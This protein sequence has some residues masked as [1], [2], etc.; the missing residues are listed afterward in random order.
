[1]NLISFE[2][3]EPL[4]KGWTSSPHSHIHHIHGM[5]L[6]NPMLYAQRSVGWTRSL[7]CYMYHSSRDGLLIDICTTLNGIKLIS[8]VLYA[9]LLNG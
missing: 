6:I 9:P 4:L 5:D 8:L 2:L 1:M 7:Q 3:V